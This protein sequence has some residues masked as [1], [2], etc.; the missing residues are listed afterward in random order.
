MGRL[1]GLDSV[2]GCLA[3]LEGA[4][5]EGKLPARIVKKGEMSTAV[6]RAANAMR[7]VSTNV[8]F[9]PLAVGTPNGTENS[10]KA[11]SF[12]NTDWR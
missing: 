11:F 10:A 2:K 6:R 12:L 9:C 7:G 5:A 1:K 4:P 8:V 3:H